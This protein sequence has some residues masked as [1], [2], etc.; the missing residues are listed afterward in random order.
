MASGQ[1]PPAIA[2]PAARA[3]VR[4]PRASLRRP[5]LRRP[6]LGDRG[7]FAP[8]GTTFPSGPQAVADVE[9]NLT[10]WRGAP[11]VSLVLSLRGQSVVR[12]AWGPAVLRDGHRAAP[13][14]AYRRAC[15]GALCRGGFRCA[16]LPSPA[17]G[18]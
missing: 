18:R 7:A 8:G 17:E 15:R 11:R 1:S 3:T 6:R 9:W 2:C 13:R 4:H 16:W 12:R 5:R 14:R 10:A